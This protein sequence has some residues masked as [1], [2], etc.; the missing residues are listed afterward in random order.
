MCVCVCV[1]I[2]HDVS[3]YTGDESNKTQ[4]P[5]TVCICLAQLFIMHSA[6]K[7]TNR[8]GSLLFSGLYTFVFECHSSFFCGHIALQVSELSVRKHQKVYAHKKQRQTY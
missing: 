1:N 5:K 2:T 8:S 6:C 3:S 4:I 7:T